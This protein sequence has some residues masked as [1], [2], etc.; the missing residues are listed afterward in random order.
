MVG[1]DTTVSC[2]PRMLVTTFVCTC[3][4]HSVIHRNGIMC[5]DVVAAYSPRKSNPDNI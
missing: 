1:I 4:V 3:N 2:Y 5:F